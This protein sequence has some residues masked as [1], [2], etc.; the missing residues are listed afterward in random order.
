MTAVIT[1]LRQRHPEG[2]LI[3]YSTRVNRVKE[4]AQALEYEAYFRCVG[5]KKTTF[6]RIIQPDCPIVVATNALGLGIDM[7]NIRAVIHVDG[8]RNIRDFGQESGRAGRDGEASDSVIMAHPD[9]VYSDARMAQFI[10]GQTCCRVILDG[11]LDGREDRQQCQ[12]H[13]QAC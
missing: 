6:N 8:P 12:V 13:E 2:K 11:Y 1:G 4:L 7:P 10:H 9:T 3:I 5:D